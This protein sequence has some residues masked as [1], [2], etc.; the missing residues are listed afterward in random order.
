MKKSL[1]L[2]LGLVLYS[3]TTT[4]KTLVMECFVFGDSIGIFKLETE[5]S[6]DSPDLFAKRDDGKWNGWC[7]KPYMFCSKGDDS[8]VTHLKG[9]QKD[10]RRKDDVKMVYDFRFLTF[11]SEGFTKKPDGEETDMNLKGTCKRINP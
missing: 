11:E 6:N 4:A 9:T 3:T 10:T 1:P 8:V 7:S 2:F 5:E